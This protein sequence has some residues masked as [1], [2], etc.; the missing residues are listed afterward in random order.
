MTKW[1]QCRG[2]KAPVD[3]SHEDYKEDFL[4]G[5]CRGKDDGDGNEGKSEVSD[6]RTNQ[7]DG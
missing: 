6:V 3:E 1:Y 4:C 5:T 7:S 2:C